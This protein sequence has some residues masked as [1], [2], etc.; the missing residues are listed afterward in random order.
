M[1]DALYSKTCINQLRIVHFLN[2]T[3]FTLVQ[4]LH[5]TLDSNENQ[6]RS[7]PQ[8]GAASVG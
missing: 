2:A 1:K 6:N 8:E 4:G 5:T 7:Y 3:L